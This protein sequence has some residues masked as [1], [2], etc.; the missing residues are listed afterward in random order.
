MLGGHGGPGRSTVALNLVTNVFEITGM[1]N[2]TID[3]HELW[4]R[5]PV[6]GRLEWTG[7]PPK[8]KAE[9]AR[10]GLPYALPVVKN[11]AVA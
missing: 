1:E 5:D 6:S 2:G 3:G 8:C 4:V 9:F 11:G 7:L 10:R